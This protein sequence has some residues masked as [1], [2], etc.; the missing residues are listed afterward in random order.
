MPRSKKSATV[1]EPPAKED[2]VFHSLDELKQMT[3]EEF[4]SYGDNI[5][6]HKYRYEKDY[7][8]HEK[9][10]FIKYQKNLLTDAPREDPFGKINY[11]GNLIKMYYEETQKYKKICSYY[12][13]ILMPFFEANKHAMFKDIMELPIDE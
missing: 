10:E 12:D 11:M 3:P 1:E 4:L 8:E 7:P 2:V 13:G 6:T 5:Y 9:Q